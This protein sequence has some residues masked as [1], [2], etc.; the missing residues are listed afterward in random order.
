[1]A[2]IKKKGTSGQ[3]KNFITRTQAVR[4]LQ[5]SL[6]DFRKLCIWKGIYPREPRNKKKASS[7]SHAATTFYYTKDIQYLLH[8]PL[9]QKFR[10]QK[11][12]EKKIARALGRGDAHNASRLERNAS[13]PE[14]TGRAKYTLDHVIRERY[15]TFIDA[16]RDLDDC[17][18]MLFLFANLPSTD[19]VPAKM[20]ARCEKLV[21]EF[22]HYLIVS[23]SLRKSFLSIKG[24]YYQATIQGQD[25]LWLVPYKFNQRVTGDVD[26]RIM[27]TFVEFYQTLLGFVNYRLYT[28][29]GLAYPP[30]FDKES[31]DQGAEL[32][33]FTLEGNSVGPIEQPKFGLTSEEQRNAKPDAKLQVEIDKLMAQL[34]V[35]EEKAKELA[36]KAD[37][38]MEDAD[39][40]T[41]ALDKFVP[42]APGGDI[43][44]QPSYS[45][46]DPSTLFSNYTFFL[47][48]ETP[49]Q[50]LEF[51][52]RAFGCKRIGW[53]AVLGAGAFT[54]NE[55][56]PSIT[57]QVV[58]RPP[59]QV[60]DEDNQSA[61]TLV[62]GS[63]VPGRIYVQP[64][65]VWDSINEEELKRADLYAPGAQLPPHLSPFVKKVRGAYDPS[66][67]LD[68]Q[69]RE[70]E[71]LEADTDD[72]EDEE[73]EEEEAEELTA[74]EVA[75]IDIDASAA[76]MEVAGSDEEDD[77]EEVAKDATFGGFSDAEEDQES[78]DEATTAAVQRQKEL[79]AEMTGV[80]LKETKVDPRTKA[81]ADARKKLSKAR[82]EEDEELER[83]KMMLSRRK[84]KILEK[85]VYSNKEKEKEAEGLRAKRRKIEKSGK[86]GVRE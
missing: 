71:E 34:N 64:Q 22:E 75:N 19:S 72:E 15:P 66:A 3:A 82:E 1:M 80:P 85:M 60:E 53:D 58:D 83:G 26:F 55:L 43:L 44:P 2:R 13:R 16:L 68:E 6:P 67:P 69:E 65:W 9:L 59:R 30:K 24:I 49:R 61:Q 79:E 57:H 17:L 52:L 48:R 76:G 51:I 12:L 10:D 25:I 33:A 62:K 18:S 40:A 32:G 54:H 27:G 11:A 78:E 56:D 38:D 31:D 42:V 50:P 8:E 7:T 37:A 14:K 81:K 35:P 46:T 21:L 86:G 45:S 20:I 74:A 36:S 28:S 29:L 4:K 39:G 77:E 70:N 5:I 23:H 41:D 47:S 84:R 63:R 73:D